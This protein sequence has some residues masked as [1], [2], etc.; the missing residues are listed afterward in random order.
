MTAGRGRDF[1]EELRAARQHVGMSSEDLANKLGYSPSMVRMIESGHRF[2]QPDFAKRC[3][4]VFAVPGTFTRL[5]ARLRDL[6]FPESFRP[7]VPSEAKARSLRI[8]E[9]VLVPGLFQTAGYARAMLSARPYTGD[10]EVEN[11]LA[12]RM[13]RQEILTREEPP[14][15]YAVLDEAVL[16]RPVGS[17]EVMRDQL[18]HLIELSRLPHILIQVIHGA[19]A[20]IGLQ[21]GFA[22]ADLPDSPGIVFLDT[23]ADG[24]TVEDA[25]IVSQV[26]QRFDA[27]RAEALSKGASL[28]MITTV[29]EERW[30]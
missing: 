5:E 10:D 30:K 7:F 29:C 9:H 22:I 23:A 28:N 24:Q 6:P 2:P 20:H 21:G 3:D 8:F 15:V 17:A 11:L 26:M 27:L 18:A 12:V 1:A 14:L 16:H 25:T 4:E 13:K 19:G